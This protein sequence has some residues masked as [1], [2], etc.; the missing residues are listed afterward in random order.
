MQPTRLETA[1]DFLRNPRKA[2]LLMR[3]AITATAELPEL[4]R[5]FQETW[6]MR[7]GVA[8]FA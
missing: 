3:L 2:R 8:S 7:D 4:D 1:A 5:M 6:A